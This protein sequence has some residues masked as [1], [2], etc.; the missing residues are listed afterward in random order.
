MALLY[1]AGYV[2]R[3]DPVTD[4]SFIYSQEHGK[5]TEELN[6][7]R[8][9]LPEDNICQWVIFSYILLHEVAS[10][11]CR[12]SLIKVL[13]IISD[14]YEL[15]HIEIRHGKTLSNILLNNYCNIYTPR[16]SKE[17]KLKILKLSNE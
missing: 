4:D 2:V 10:D 14:F 13:M 16:S 9:T 11:V 15:S 17:P 6:R 1:V 7:G 5:Y 3:K 12:T 8:L